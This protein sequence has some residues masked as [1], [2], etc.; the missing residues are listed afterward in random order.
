MFSQLPKSSQL[1]VILKSKT[2]SLVSASKS[3]LPINPELKLKTN[4]GLKTFLWHILSRTL[5]LSASY[6]VPFRE[7][8]SRRALSTA[9]PACTLAKP[10]GS[11]CERLGSL[12]SPML[13][14][15]PP[16]ENKVSVFIALPAGDHDWI[17]SVGHSMPLHRVPNE[18]IP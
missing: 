3:F 1:C 16:F 4:E 2:I 17:L 13:C 6:L 8:F 9:G 5:L 15:Q 10:S 7:Q 11:V 14:F 18:G 12:N